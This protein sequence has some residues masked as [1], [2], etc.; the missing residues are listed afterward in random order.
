MVLENETSLAKIAY[1][2]PP[3]SMVYLRQDD[4]FYLKTEKK[5][6]VWRIIQMDTASQPITIA[7]PPPAQPTPSPQE[8][9]PNNS[10]KQ[11]TIRIQ[12]MH[13]QLYLIAH[14]EPLDGRL[15]FWA[16][17]GGGHSGAIFACQREA[18]KKHLGQ[19][20]Y[21]LLS[22]DM[23]NMDYV[24][25]PMNRYG[26]PLVNIRGETIFS[27]FAHLIRGQEKP[28][29]PIL[30]FD[31]SNIFNDTSVQ[32]APCVWLG[33]KPIYRNGDYEHAARSKCRNWQT[34]AP[35]EG[36]L[37]AHLPPNATGLV[38]KDN[39]YEESCSKQCLI[40]CIQII[41]PQASTAESNNAHTP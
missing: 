5:E 9:F 2:L 32:R 34:N 4:T 35:T 11:V 36:A 24:V 29:A 27:D 28:R 31:G 21:P 33:A 40:L 13:V 7:S 10:G 37:A 6:N 30:T 41:T 3:G 20:F 39:I 12:I 22:T 17:L 8:P 15:R 14:P 1:S 18:N 26:L 19:S 23:F 25:P 38:D 16:K